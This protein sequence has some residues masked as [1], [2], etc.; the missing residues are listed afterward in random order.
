VALQQRNGTRQLQLS[1]L[2]PQPHTHTTHTCT[3]AA[4][5]PHPSRPPQPRAHISRGHKV[6][7]VVQ[8][9]HVWE[10]AG[11]VEGGAPHGAAHVQNGGLLTLAWGV[12]AREGFAGEGWQ[13]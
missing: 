9:Q 3:Y 10:G 12:G 1:R 8:A 11:Q 2:T 6:L 5:G 13:R 7:G 4:T